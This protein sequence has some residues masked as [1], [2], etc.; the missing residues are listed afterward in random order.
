MKKQRTLNLGGVCYHSVQN[1]LSFHPLST[2]IKIKNNLSVVLYGCEVGLLASY[3]IGAG[4]S[5][6]WG[7]A[8]GA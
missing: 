6:P 1:L 8:A 5:F 2:S 4:G 7:K 3:P